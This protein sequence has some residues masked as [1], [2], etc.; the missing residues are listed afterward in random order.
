MTRI[1]IAAALAALVAACNT[2]ETIYLRH[3]TTAQTVQCGPYSKVGN[4]AAVYAV[5]AQQ[6]RD[7]VADYQRQGFERTPESS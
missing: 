6:L 1:L 3:P 4:A 5:M 2:S 7:C